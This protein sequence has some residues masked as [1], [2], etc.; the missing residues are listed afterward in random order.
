M[1]KKKPTD[2]ILAVPAFL[3][4]EERKAYAELSRRVCATVK[5]SDAMEEIWTRD[6]IDLTWDVLWYRALHAALGAR[7]QD[8]ADDE[9]PDLRFR[10]GIRNIEIVQR[11]AATAE[12]RRNEAYRQIERRREVFARRLRATLEQVESNVQS[13]IE[14]EIESE[15]GPDIPQITDQSGADVAEKGEIESNE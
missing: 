12:H 9:H 4:G 10:A 8:W 11:L 2:L 7:L 1:S 6:V 15:I 5:P 13:E 14:T 3:E